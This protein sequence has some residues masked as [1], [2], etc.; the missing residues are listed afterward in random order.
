L[1]RPQLIQKASRLTHLAHPP[2]L[3]CHFNTITEAAALSELRRQIL[4]NDLFSSSDSQEHCS[5]SRLPQKRC[6]S[7]GLQMPRVTTGSSGRWRLDEFRSHIPEFGQLVMTM[8]QQV[9]REF[10][11]K[12]HPTPPY[13]S[14]QF[15]ISFLDF[16]Q[17]C[18]ISIRGPVSRKA[19]RPTETWLRAQ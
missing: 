2:H 9:V 18:G 4:R 17:K 7:S 8:S 6:S 1:K 14:S 16:N 15:A 5:L 13:R 11:P 3:P 12:R 10:G 19:Y